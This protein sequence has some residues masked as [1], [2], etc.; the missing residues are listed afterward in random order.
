MYRTLQAAL[1]AAALS[2]VPAGAGTAVRLELEDLVQNAELVFEGYVLSARAI[3]SPAGRVETEYFV[4][5][6]RSYLGEPLGT[7]VFSIPGGTLPDGSGM[8]VPGLPRLEPGDEALFFLTESGTA[9]WRMPVGLAQGVLELVVDAEGRRALARSQAVLHL[10]DPRTGALGAH[11]DLAGEG[12]L[13][14]YAETV[15]R[16]ERAAA[17]KRVGL[18]ARQDSAAGRGGEER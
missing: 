17:R 16:I 2:L 11:A 15:T 9:G 6:H 7:R 8:L 14:A 3:P 12:A 1:V 4:S 10:V 18:P 5:V 13:L